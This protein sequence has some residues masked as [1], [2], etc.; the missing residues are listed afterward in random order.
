MTIL[1]R[2]ILPMNIEPRNDESSADVPVAQVRRRWG[3]LNFRLQPTHAFILIVLYAVIISAVTW[4]TIRQRAKPAAPVAPVAAKAELIETPAAP[5]GDRV[6]VIPLPTKNQDR[7]LM[8]P[9][10]P[11]A[12]EPMPVHPPPK[13]IERMPA[14]VAEEPAPEPEPDAPARR[15]YRSSGGDICVRHGMHKVVT[16]GGRSWRCR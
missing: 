8:Q 13:P 2:D 12:E 15:R 5:K 4:V 11:P 6:R 14:P 3:N 16:H 9:D 7:A 10:A 1:P